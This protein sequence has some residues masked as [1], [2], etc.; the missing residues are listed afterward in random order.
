MASRGITGGSDGQAEG[1]CFAELCVGHVEDVTEMGWVQ[2][3]FN[4]RYWVGL[5]LSLM[6]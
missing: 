2:A 1:D 4:H 3:L 5:R 6:Q